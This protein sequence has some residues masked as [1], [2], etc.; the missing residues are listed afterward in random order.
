MPNSN[1]HYDMNRSD[2]PFDINICSIIHD[3]LKTNDIVD[4]I[5]GNL[6]LKSNYN[7]IVLSI[8]SD[9][10]VNISGNLEVKSDLN[11]KGQINSDG[12]KVALAQQ[13]E[14]S[15]N[16]LNFDNSYANL[17][18]FNDLS[19]IVYDLCS[20]IITIYGNIDNIDLSLNL[21]N[22]DISNLD[23]SVNTLNNSINDIQNNYVLKNSD[24][25]LNNLEINERLII[26]NEIITFNVNVDTK[27]ENHSRYNEGSNLS[28]RI[29]NVELNNINL[30][31]GKTYRF[32]QEDIDNSGHRLRFYEDEERNNEITNN[33]FLSNEEPG[34]N[35]SYSQ[36]TITN[37]DGIIYFQCQNH[38][39]MGGLINI[40]NLTN[41][42]NNNF[43]FEN[44]A[45]NNANIGNLNAININISGNLLL[46]NNDI[47]NTFSNI[48]NSLV[49]IYDI[50]NN[51]SFST[52]TVINGQDAS[53]NNLDVYGSLNSNNIILNN[54]NVNAKLNT[55]DS[56]FTSVN[57]KFD[58]IDSSF[59]NVNT[60]FDTID[61]SFI[62]VNTKFDT[63]DSSF[64]NVNSKFDTIDSSFINVNNKLDTID[65]SFTSVNN[66]L[67]TIDSSFNKIDISLISIQDSLNN[68]NI[69]NGQDASFQNIDISGYLKID[70]SNVAIKDDVDASFALYT[71][72]SDL[73]NKTDLQSGNLDLSFQNI[74][75][76]GYLKIDGSNVAIKD[77]V[78]ASFTLYTLTNDLYT[79]NDL[80][81][82][83]LDLSFQNVDISGA[84]KID[85]SNII[86][87]PSQTSNSGKYLTTN[88]S[89]LSWGTVNAGGGGISSFAFFTLNTPQSITSVRPS[90]SILVFDNIKTAD[91]TSNIVLDTSA[92]NQGR[93]DITDE[94][95]YKIDITFTCDA[96]NGNRVVSI[97]QLFINGTADTNCI[98]Y[99]YSRDNSNGENTGN[100]NAILTLSANT[101]IE[102]FVSKTINQGTDA[103]VGTNIAIMKI[104]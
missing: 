23:F 90:S 67:D 80:E 84:L 11:V 60:K 100:I 25:C 95:T 16:N 63:I 103:I 64:I 35:G 78:D 92:P 81:S 68:N 3:S 5:S 37:I 54:I 69:I 49:D 59:I 27:T 21:L 19:N 39:Y 71:L 8:P 58:T 91:P 48:D 20:N 31:L 61:S 34:N 85:G 56:S 18:S 40:V 70:G 2:L 75:I 41:I 12:L 72:T 7:D 57:T 22:T 102:F 6:I 83:N 47:S 76:S 97:G 1:N 98:C 30:E 101:Y 55:I 10:V 66:K 42:I 4:G 77:D 88:G 17:I 50:L 93:I 62:N 38:N 36:I 28:Y 24:T 79:K 32:L 73:Y 43:T 13:I 94:G 86:P 74:D 14:A 51:S 46:N 33:V 52:N 9:K 44:F 96:T 87:I 26:N 65:S 99:T 104:A 45:I 82:G 15:F 89:N 53:F 29:N